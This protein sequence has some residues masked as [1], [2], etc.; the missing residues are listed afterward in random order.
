[1]IPY[2]TVPFEWASNL[3][4]ASPDELKLLFALLLSYPLAGVLKRIPDDKPWAK[5][6]FIIATSTFFLLGLFDLWAGAATILIQ[7]G[8]T[9][10]IA[11]YISGPYMPWLSFVFNMGYMSISHIFRQIVADPTRV[12]I[13]GAQMVLVMKLTAFAWNVFD[14]SLPD[15]ELDSY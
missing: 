5:N 2:I 13:T 1:M 9:Y 8:G 3:S 12:D 14:G 4:G 10:A 7:A 11:V 6:V 15:S